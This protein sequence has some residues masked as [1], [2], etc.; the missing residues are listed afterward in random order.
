MFIDVIV[1]KTVTVDDAIE[2]NIK[3]QEEVEDLKLQLIEKNASIANLRNDNIAIAMRNELNDLRVKHFN[4]YKAMHDLKEKFEQS[5]II[6]KEY[7]DQ[8]STSN[9][10]T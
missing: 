4:L 9:I 1:P 2:M 10:Y 5:E 6:V 8:V 3:L 7:D